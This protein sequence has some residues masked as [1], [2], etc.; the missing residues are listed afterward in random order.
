MNNDSTS[1]NQNQLSILNVDWSAG[2]LRPAPRQSDPARRETFYPC[3]CPQCLRTRYLRAADARRANVCGSCQR[4]AAGK[5]GYV[6][7]LRSGRFNIIES[8]QE[9]QRSNP[10]RPERIV[11]DWI[12][13]CAIPFT[14]QHYFTVGG[15]GWV[16][17][18]VIASLAV[19]VRGYW[20]I[21]ERADKDA[22]LVATWPGQVLFIDANTVLKDALNVRLALYDAID[23]VG[24]C[25]D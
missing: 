1:S 19:E 20:H 16:I 3:T 4:S 24:V 11:R 14:H 21:R 12:A 18:F 25:H 5:A 7:A 13:A 2:E 22:R 23:R 10:S 8:I 6:A 9:R 17:D 15:D